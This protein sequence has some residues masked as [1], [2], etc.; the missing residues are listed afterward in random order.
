MQEKQQRTRD[1][2]SDKLFMSP[3][4]SLSFCS[5]FYIWK[6]LSQRMGKAFMDVGMLMNVFLIQE[7]PSSYIWKLYIKNL[8]YILF[9]IL[10]KNTSLHLS[11]C[12]L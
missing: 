2:T 4:S 12:F 8:S 11:V 9:L 5:L 7:K 10:L 3:F 1:L 6:A